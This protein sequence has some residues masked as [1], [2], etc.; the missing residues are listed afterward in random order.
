M[1]NMSFAHLEGWQQMTL[2]DSVLLVQ[3]EIPDWIVLSKEA[4]ASL[5]KSPHSSKECY[6]RQLLENAMT[7]ESATIY[8]G[9]ESVLQLGPLKECWFHLTDTCN[10]SCRHCLFAASPAKDRSIDQQSLLQTI[11][12][13]LLLGC[14]LFSFTGGEPFVY[15]EFLAILSELLRNNPEC[16]AAVLTNGMLLQ[17]SLTD[18]QQMERLHLQI[19]LDG[20]EKGHDSL[21]GRGTFQAVTRNLKALHQAD[22][23]FTLSV[24]VSRDN[25]DDLPALV[26]LGASLGAASIH[27][28][29]HFIRGKGSAE[30]FCSPEE[31]FPKIREAWLLANKLGLKID[32]IETL[33][34]QVFSTPGTRYDLSS[35]AWESIAIGP[36]GVVYPSPALI[37]LKQCGCGSVDEGLAHVWNNSKVL[38]QIRKSSLIDSAEYRKNPLKY[39]VGGGDIDHSMIHAETWVGGDPYVELYN[40][41]ILQLIEDQAALYTASGHP[42]RLRMGDVRHDCP[43]EETG[44]EVALTHCN[45]L[46][47]LASNGEHSAVRE[48]YGQAAISANTDIL[49]PLAP[50]Q[51]EADVVPDS[52]KLHSYGCGSPVTDGAPA[53]G[54]TLVDLGSGGGVECFM[55]AEAVGKEGRVVGIDMTDEMLQLANEGRKEVTSR[56]GYQN[57]EFKKGFLEQIPL[58]NGFADVVISNC[59][60]NLSPD[61]RMTY[62]EIFRI[63]KPGGRLVVSDIVTDTAIPTQIKNNVRYR[64]ECLGGAMQQEE[65]VAMME[66]AGFVTIRFIKRFPYRQVEG[67]N[68]FSLTY[69]AIKPEVETEGRVE[70]IYRGPQGAIITENGT[71]L[72]KGRVTPVSKREASR[73]GDTVFQLDE[74]GAVN[75]IQM[76]NSCCA[77]QTAIPAVGQPDQTTTSSCCDPQEKKT[78]GCMVCGQ[79]LE[80]FQEAQELHCSYCGRSFQANAACKENHFVCDDCHKESGVEAIRAICRWTEETDLITLLKLIRS[81]PAIPMH[82]PEHHAM[83]PAIILTAFR[84]SGGTIDQEVINSA[85]NRGAGVPGGACGFWG[86]CGAAIGAGIAA[87][88]ILSATPLTPSPRQQAQSFSAHILGKVA[89]YKGG[90]CCQRETW[91]T[92]TETAALSK[93][94]FGLRLAAKDTVACDQYTRNKECIRKACPLWETRDR[95]SA[96]ALTFIE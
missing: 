24:A 52:A 14:K 67:M 62:Q 51:Q 25:I 83:M 47:S 65:L 78:E 66:S 41:I 11:D 82:G 60:I 95:S 42:I 26:S 13:A 32:N 68:F 96:A 1:D 9:R 46:I 73:L 74:Q 4:A 44:Q 19:S 43:E 10:L 39:L 76:T 57:V 3:P 45:C 33:R 21:R 55:A 8:Q 6:E 56:L 92:L 70:V 90:R 77:P 28:L 17:E 37:G 61:K 72:Y 71:I 22:I 20:L 69:E 94:F 40:K 27:F 16:H 64:G 50:A 36:D 49:N 7:I 85:I 86:A 63:L 87:S 48:F 23:P 80:Y 31:M 54:E 59:V 18:L 89:T 34:S 91:L 30:Q 79:E 88:S 93:S 84:N 15:P 29:Y 38:Q 75:N 58:D 53:Q 5:G 12:E 2:H 35:T 81:H